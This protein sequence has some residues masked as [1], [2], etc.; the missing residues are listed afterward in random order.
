MDSD[1]VFISN[2]EFCFYSHNGVGQKCAKDDGSAIDADKFA[3]RNTSFSRAINRVAGEEGF[4][5]ILVNN[6]IVQ[7]VVYC[8]LESGRYK[9]TYPV[10]TD[11]LTEANLATIRSGNINSINMALIE[12]TPA[13][14]ADGE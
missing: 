1:E 13:T 8:N 7:S 4:Y 3:A 11:E 10:T 9:G 2:G 5:K 14:P 12:A 6:Y